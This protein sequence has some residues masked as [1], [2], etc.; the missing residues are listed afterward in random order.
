[1]H[2]L[3]WRLQLKCVTTVTTKVKSSHSLFSLSQIL[4]TTLDSMLLRIFVLHCV[5]NQI[6]PKDAETNEKCDQHCKISGHV[7]RMHVIRRQII[8]SSLKTCH[9]TCIIVKYWR[10]W[11]QIRITITVLHSTEL[12]NQHAREGILKERRVIQPLFHQC[13][14][15]HSC[16]P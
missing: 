5:F 15:Q 6:I 11:R 4:I 1:M 16:L 8:I 7:I 14:D 13:Y 3:V 10:Q 9:W 2:Q 12:R